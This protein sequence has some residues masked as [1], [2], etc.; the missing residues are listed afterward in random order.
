MNI[1]FEKFARRIIVDMHP[2]RFTFRDAKGDAVFSVE[3]FLFL[4]NSGAKSSIISIGELAPEKYRNKPDIY[5]VDIFSADK[6]LPP[7]STVT[8]SDLVE[9]IFQY[10]LLWFYRKDIVPLLRP[11]VF[12][13]GASRFDNFFVNPKDELKTAAKK[14][15]AFEV[16]FD[17]T[18]L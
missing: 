11:I 16:F 5:R 10:G 12:I 4:D 2:S 3:T 17:K 9:I 8:R 13:L 15:G 1:V 6:S 18:E 14:G 7:K